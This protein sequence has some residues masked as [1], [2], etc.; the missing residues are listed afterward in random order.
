[1]S[2][3]TARSASPAHPGLGFCSTE[4]TIYADTCVMQPGR[5]VEC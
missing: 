5:L 3:V 1:M 2:L 4:V